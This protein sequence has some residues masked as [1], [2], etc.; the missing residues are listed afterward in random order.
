MVGLEPREQPRLVTC[1]ECGVLAKL[2]IVPAEIAKFGQAVR[3]STP[4]VHCAAASA[5][6]GLVSVALSVLHKIIDQRLPL[7]TVH[8][9]FIGIALVLAGMALGMTGGKRGRIGVFAGFLAL[10]LLK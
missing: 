10:V 5:T 7:G 9:V 3:I 2:P 4:P 6:V 8:E 1:P